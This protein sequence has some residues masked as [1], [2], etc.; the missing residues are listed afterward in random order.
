MALGSFLWAFCPCS[1]L[2]GWSRF[3]LPPAEIWI[4]PPSGKEISRDMVFTWKIYS[5]SLACLPV[6]SASCLLTF[7]FFSWFWAKMLSRKW[8]TCPKFHLVPLLWIFYFAHIFWLEWINLCSFTAT[9]LFS[10][11]GKYA[12]QPFCSQNSQSIEERSNYFFGG[13]NSELMQSILSTSECD[14]IRS[15]PPFVGSQI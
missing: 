3:P 12:S 7:C 15:F 13:F 4:L 1:S 10:N 2:T 5:H 6:F 9:L 8:E 14:A 11:I